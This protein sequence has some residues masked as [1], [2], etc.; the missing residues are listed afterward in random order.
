MTSPPKPIVVGNHRYYTSRPARPFLPTRPVS[1]ICGGKQECRDRRHERP[2]V[3]FQ[4]PASGAFLPKLCAETVIDP[5]LETFIDHCTEYDIGIRIRSPATA[6]ASLTSNSP[7]SGPR[8]C[9]EHT[10]ASMDVSSSGL[11]MAALVARLLGRLR[12]LADSHQ[13]RAC[14][15]H[16]CV[17]SAKSRLIKPES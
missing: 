9:S 17:T 11:E 1:S 7:R 5:V 12:G 10:L 16:D 6:A 8:L 2:H 14:I 4:I 3:T 13:R 15:G